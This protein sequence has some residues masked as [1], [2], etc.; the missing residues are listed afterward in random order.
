MKCFT[1]T[2]A[3]GLALAV[4]FCTTAAASDRNLAVVAEPSSSRVSGDTS[5]A[6]LNDGHAPESSHVRGRGSYGNWPARGTQWVQYEWS[7]PV[8]TQKIDVYWW[9]DRRGVR[10][11]KACRLLYWD[12]E[13]QHHTLEVAKN[14]YGISGKDVDVWR[15]D[16]K[17]RFSAVAGGGA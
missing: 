13:K 12:G 3:G 16:G 8:S 10:L 5:L 14:N 4:L 1:M 6:A 17:H 7:Q 15:I 2:L 11:P 9:D